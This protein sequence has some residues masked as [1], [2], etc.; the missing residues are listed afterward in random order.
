ML[1]VLGLVGLR[2]Y[3]LQ[4]SQHQELADLADRNRIRLRRV[5]APRGLVFDRRHRPLVDTQPTFNASLVPEDSNNLSE[6]IE[7]LEGYLGQNQVAD[8]IAAAEE[9]GRPPYEPVVVQERLDWPQVVALEA[10]QLDLPGVSLD[11][12]PGRHYLYGKMAAHLLGY[13]GEVK[14]TI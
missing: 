13:V 12:T 14:K 11:I 4:V 5:P 2:L 10:H 8:K 7:R 3:Y 6:T 9:S 1:S